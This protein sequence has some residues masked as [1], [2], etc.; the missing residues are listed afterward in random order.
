VP[1]VNLPF[2]RY[3]YADRLAQTHAAMNAAGVNILFA[4][5]PSNISW[6]TGYDGWSFCVHQG[7]LIPIGES[8]VWWG[9]QMDTQ[10][11]MR[12]VYMPGERI[13]GYH[14]DYLMSIERHLMQH[15]AGLLRE[16]GFANK[17]TGVEM[18]N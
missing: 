8:P 16:S 4:A 10:G 17:R 1:A 6:L 13:R 14:D 12:T 15:L 2:S 11:A 18:E 7:V 9:R 3:E 5:N